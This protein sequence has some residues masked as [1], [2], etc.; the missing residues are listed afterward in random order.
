MTDDPVDNMD[1][2]PS[3]GR[4]SLPYPRR[5]IDVLALLLTLGGIGWALDA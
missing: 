1:G 5:L 4:A 2:V 3:S